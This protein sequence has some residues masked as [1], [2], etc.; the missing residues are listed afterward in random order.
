MGLLAA[1]LVAACPM[2]IAADGSLMSES[3][4]V[5][6]I[7]AVALGAYW[8]LDGSSP[9]RFASVGLLVGL[10][11]LT[12]ADA[13]F[14]APILACALAWRVRGRSPARRVALGAVLLC[15]M[16]VVLVPWVVY[17]SSRMGGTVLLSSNSGN[18]LEGANCAGTYHGKLLGAWD[19]RCLRNKPP[20]VS[21]LEWASESRG[22]AVD[23]ARGHA[24]DLPLVAATRVMRVWGLWS[25]VDQARLEAIETR[26]VPWQ[27]FAWG[28]DLV[29]LVLAVVGAALLVRR[30]TELAPLVAIVAAVVVTAALSNGNQRFRLAAEPVVAVAAA[31]AILAAWCARRPD[32]AS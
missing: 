29:I 22:V 1:L 31:V 30:G 5:A 6:L 9:W 27:I 11:A 26:S 4:Y 7:T 24:V 20:Q 12:R 2:L 19:A 8:A 32:P 28:Y 14:L 18:M 16:V 17:S 23:Y 21:E 25:P 10:A 15:A 13:L 3:L